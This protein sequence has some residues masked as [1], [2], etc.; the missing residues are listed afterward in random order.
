MLKIVRTKPRNRFPFFTGFS[1]NTL[2][3]MVMSA[4]EGR[5]LPPQNYSASE[6]GKYLFHELLEQL[7]AYRFNMPPHLTDEDLEMLVRKTLIYVARGCDRMSA[8]S[9]NPALSKLSH[10]NKTGSV[11]PSYNYVYN[12]LP[13]GKHLFDLIAFDFN[14]AHT[15]VIHKYLS[16]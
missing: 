16:V 12:Y 1:L 7:K 5:I 8:L 11:A 14:C 15:I 10:K 3:P 2:K 13:P 9:S 6:H 4:E